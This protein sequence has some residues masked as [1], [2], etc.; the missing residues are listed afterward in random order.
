[1]EKKVIIYTL[2]DCGDCKQAKDF[3][4]ENEIPYEEKSVRDPENLNEM[5]EKYKRLMVPTIIMGDEVYTGFSSN[6]LVIAFAIDKLKKES[7]ETASP[8]T[9]S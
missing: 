8:S 3:L 9:N 7:E 6:R 4:A 1:M 5:T 2:P